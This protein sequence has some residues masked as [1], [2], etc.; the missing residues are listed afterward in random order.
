MPTRRRLMSSAFVCAAI[1]ALVIGIIATGPRPSLGDTTKQC[2][3]GEIKCCYVEPPCGDCCEKPK[4]DGV[5]PNSAWLPVF[6]R[7]TLWPA[8][9][10]LAG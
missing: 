10:V 6:L 1:V 3:W 9:R 4:D 2:S 5:E 7:D 8:V